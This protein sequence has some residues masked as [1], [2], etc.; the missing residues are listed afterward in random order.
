MT[1]L[2]TILPRIINFLASACERIK[3]LRIKNGR[4]KAEFWSSKTTSLQTKSL[5]VTQSNK[6]IYQLFTD[7]Y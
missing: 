6:M 5:Y 1:G 4:E 2:R 3:H 7:D